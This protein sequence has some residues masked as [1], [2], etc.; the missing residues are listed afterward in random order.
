MVFMRKS[1]LSHDKQD[2]LIEHVV[3]GTTARTAS[4]LCGVNHKTR[5][6]YFH[7]LREVIAF[8]PEAESEAVFG[9]EVGVDESGISK[10]ERW[11]LVSS[12]SL[13]LGL[14]HL[15]FPRVSRT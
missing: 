11:P 4:V 15:G 8:E 13:L 14:N 5:A 3:A 1:P 6:Y 12:H 10:N 2:R 7:H 9:C